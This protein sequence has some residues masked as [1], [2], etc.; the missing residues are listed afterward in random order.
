MVEVCPDDGIGHLFLEHPFTTTRYRP[1]EEKKVI[2]GV[3]GA[4]NQTAL[5]TY[6]EDVRQLLLPDRR[7]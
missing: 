1:P 2:V 7:K 4:G 3:Y 5:D 6:M